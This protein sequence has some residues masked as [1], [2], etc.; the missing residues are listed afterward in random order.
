MKRFSVFAASIVAGALVMLTPLEAQERPAGGQNNDPKKIDRGRKLAFPLWKA[1]LP[2]GS[3]I[4]A[5]NAINSISSQ[6]YVL[7]GVA[8]VTEV[9]VTT[10][11]NFH[12]RFYYLEMLSATSPA[13]VPGAQI[14]IDH[15]QAALAGAAQDAA[16][17]TA[18][19]VVKNYPAT[20]HASTI[21][22]RLDSAEQLQKLFE[23]VERVWLTGES[24]VYTPTGLRRY[25]PNKEIKNANDDSGSGGPGSDNSANE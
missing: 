5:R 12:P 6:Q 14:A 7:D 18:S 8:R 3:Y 9:N 20:T 11:G 4:V 19:K 13:D 22:Y 10:T 21:E 15:A 16:P 2:G 24:E 1:E 23:S 17:E 25:N